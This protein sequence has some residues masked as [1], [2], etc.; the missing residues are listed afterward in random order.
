MENLD[1]TTKALLGGLIAV[2]LGAG[3]YYLYKNKKLDD[4]PAII[5][6]PTRLEEQPELRQSSAEV[7]M[8][9]QQKAQQAQ[10]ELARAQQ[11]IIAAELEREQNNARILEYRNQIA[12]IQSQITALE[13]Q[14]AQINQQK[15][16]ADSLVQQRQNELNNAQAQYNAQKNATSSLLQQQSQVQKKIQDLYDEYWRVYKNDWVIANNMNYKA[17]K[18]PLDNDL[19]SINSKI[20]IQSANENNAWAQLQNAQNNLNIAINERD[21]IARDLSAFDSTNLAPLRTQINALEQTINM[22]VIAYNAAEEKIA[23]IRAQIGAATG[24]LV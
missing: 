15:L 23:K 5:N 7:D 8:I 11:E 21:R 4:F 14:K 18:Q 9:A 20:T 1:N 19:L 3:G 2:G 16:G 10:A 12:Q 24:V 13:Q 6:A 22:Y 17:K